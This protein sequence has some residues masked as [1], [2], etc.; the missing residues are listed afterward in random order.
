MCHDT[1]SI[2]HGGQLT[3]QSRVKGVVLTFKANQILTSD[4]LHEVMALD[5]WNVGAPFV[6]GSCQFTH[7]TRIFAFRLT[8]TWFR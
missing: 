6:R 2:A 1:A 7:K 8:S 5:D 4:I 3:L